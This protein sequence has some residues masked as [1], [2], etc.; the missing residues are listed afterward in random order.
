[1][2]WTPT[3]SDVLHDHLDEDIVIV[4]EMGPCVDLPCEFESN[5]REDGVL[6]VLIGSDILCI[7]A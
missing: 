1:M 3:H 7:D 5:V 4:L 6:D 2:T